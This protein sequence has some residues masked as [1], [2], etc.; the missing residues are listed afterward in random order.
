M[1]PS[2]PFWRLSPSTFSNSFDCGPRATI[3]LATVADGD[4]FVLIGT[5]SEKLNISFHF[6]PKTFQKMT[7]AGR[8]ESQRGRAAGAGAG[9]YQPEGHCAGARRLWRDALYGVRSGPARLR[10]AGA[11]PHPKPG[12]RNGSVWPPC[13]QTLREGTTKAT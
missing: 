8:L 1:A 10:R 3:Y 4:P 12:R 2:V 11:L 6:L 5:I 7:N 9:R 13:S